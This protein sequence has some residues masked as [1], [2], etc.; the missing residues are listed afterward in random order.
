MVTFY[1]THCPKCNILEKKLKAANIDYT[2]N[3]DV[4]IMLSKGLR[5][6]P[7]LEVDGKIYTFTQAIEWLKNQEG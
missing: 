2:E 3:N 7:A 1:S 4:N 5:T 6:A